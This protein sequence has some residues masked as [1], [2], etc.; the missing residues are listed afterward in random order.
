MAI[1][2]AFEPDPDLE[3]IKPP[4]AEEARPASPR[5]A[6]PGPAVQPADPAQW[7]QTVPLAFPVTVDGEPLTFITLRRVTGKQVT[8]L[9]MQDDE[10]HSLNRRA[11]ALV[12]GVHPD[13][14]DGL[15]ADD[16]VNVLE[17]AR[18]F[19]PRAL[20]GADLLEVA[21]DVLALGDAAEPA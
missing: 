3:P 4:A 7:S 5:P 14:L 9:L 2:S 20:Q 11:R 13:V 18:P 12:A 1:Q 8:D 6:S 19:L 10:E 21:A 16:L 15:E 17:A